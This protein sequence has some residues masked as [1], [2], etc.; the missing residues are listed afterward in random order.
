M[1]SGLIIQDMKFVGYMLIVWDYINYAKTKNIAVGYGRESVAGSLV[2]YALKITDINPIVYG[3]LFE[4]FINSQTRKPEIVIDICHNGKHKIISEIELK[5][6]FPFAY[7]YLLK[8]KSILDKRDNGKPNSVAWYA[9][10]RTQGLN[11]T[12]GKKILF[13]PMNKEPNFILSEY[14]DAT[15]YSGYCI[16]YE[17]DYKIYAVVHD[18]NTGQINITK[19]SFLDNTTIGEVDFEKLRVILLG[20]FRHSKSKPLDEFIF[21]PS[22]DFLLT[23]GDS[24]VC[25]G[26]MTAIANLKSRM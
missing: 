16:K 17:G 13:S 21:N 20:V 1:C 2:S 6:N 14:E 25:I 11:T 3:L 4:S 8:S 15:F 23:A 9:F 19:G 24:L 5:E 7:E 26:Y 22:D 18:T 10:G 12:F